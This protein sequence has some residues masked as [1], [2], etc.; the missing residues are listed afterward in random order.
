[1]L[2]PIPKGLPIGLLKNTLVYDVGFAD[3]HHLNVLL[4][5]TSQSV[6]TEKKSLDANNFPNDKIRTLNAGVITNGYTSTTEYSL[7][8]QLGRLS[9]DYKKKYLVTA[10]VRRDGSSRFGKNNKYSIF[11]SFS[12]GYRISE[13][14]FFSEDSFISELKLR[15]SWGESGNFNITNFGSVAL[16]SSTNYPLS[17]GISPGLSAKTSPNFN[18]SWEQTSSTNIGLDLGLFNSQLNFIADYYITNTEDLLFD[19]PV[20]TQSGFS[21]SL[22]NVGEIK[23]NGLELTLNGNFQW[24]NF[25][26]RPGVNFSR[27]HHEVVSLITDKPIIDW[28]W[29]TE[30]GGEVGAF[31]GYKSNGRIFSTQEELDNLPHHS[32]AELFNS[33]IWEDVTGDGYIKK[34]DRTVIG[35]P[36]P[37]YT[38]NISSGFGYKGIDANIII[39]SVQ[40]FDVFYN[41][42]RDFITAQ[43]S[44]TNKLGD[45]SKNTYESANQSG[46]YLK[47]YLSNRPDRKHY[48]DSDK[49]LYDGSFVR[50]RNI[51]LGYT[52]PKP[53]SEKIAIDKFRIY[54][55]ANNLFT[56]TDYPGFDPEVNS[57]SRA[58]R[59][60]KTTPRFGRD[61]GTFPTT[62]N[63]VIGLNINF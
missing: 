60:R 32:K 51:T 61:L 17:D 47:Y 22:Q 35:S 10:T 52:L 48:R 58:N 43:G 54:I 37:D 34:D 62:K 9:Y 44:F 41:L 56:F 20:P 6:K 4:G 27:T 28:A 46:K 55:S 24:G 2:N 36:H 11:P 63:F 14:S 53:L 31:F 7:L 45:L 30:V 21:K 57:D 59:G 16:L 12:L 23:G 18:L 40:G 1:M 42:G 38:L 13:E 49:N 29:I 25:L 33:Y 19:V 8:S 5:Y 39:Q 26:W 50:I 15:G 3:V